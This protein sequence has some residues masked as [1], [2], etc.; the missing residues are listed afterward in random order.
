MAWYVSLSSKMEWV[1]GSETAY[2]VFPTASTELPTK[3]LTYLTM[4]SKKATYVTH[5]IVEDPSDRRKK[6]DQAGTERGFIVM[7]S[8]GQGSSV[9]SNF[10]ASASKLESLGI[11]SRIDVDEVPGERKKKRRGKS[12]AAAT[13][14]K[15]EEEEEETQEPQHIDLATLADNECRVETMARCIHNAHGP[16][17]TVEIAEGS[18]RQV[19][20]MFTAKQELL[21]DDWLKH[22]TDALRTSGCRVMDSKVAPANCPTDESGKVQQGGA[23][24]ERKK[25]ESQAQAAEND[26]LSSMMGIGEEK[27]K[28]SAPEKKARPEEGADGGYNTEKA[29]EK[30][31]ELPPWL[32][33]RRRPQP[34]MRLSLLMR[35]LIRRRSTRRKF[36]PSWTKTRRSSRRAR[37][38][39]ISWLS[40]RSW[41]KLTRTTRT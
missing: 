9:N 2:T 3:T 40:L 33:K 23:V 41:T 19:L 37:P 14:N 18:H 4:S 31:K 15:E 5:A 16:G 25:V 36:R 20:N 17:F 21:L 13:E 34:S 12:K 24:F 30:D 35:T 32:Q 29:P 39:R 11:V 26:W 27:P 10:E 7:S 1:D 8:E 28:R 6:K 38:R 22:I